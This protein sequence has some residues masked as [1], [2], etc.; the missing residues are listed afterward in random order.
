M[1]KTIIVFYSEGYCDQVAKALSEYYQKLADEV[2]VLL[3]NEAQYTAWGT[4]RF[5]DGLYRFSMR[6][7]PNINRFGGFISYQYN[8]KFKNKMSKNVKETES[9]ETE[10][11][12]EEKEESFKKLKTRFRKM[13]NILLRFNP[14]VVV[15]TTPVSLE[16]ALK[17]RERLKMPVQICVAITDYCTN[18]GMINH[19]VDK[20]LVQNAKI[21]QT[22]STF[23]INEDIVDVL[24]TPICQSIAEEYDRKAQLEAF[25]VTNKDLKNILIVS[26]RCGCARVI[27]AFKDI[28]PY[29][30]E[31]NIFVMANDSRNIHSFVKSYTKASKSTENIYLI[32]SIDDMAKLYS[33][34]DVIVTSP[35]AA[36]TYEAAVRGIP[37]VLL[38]PANQLEEG[39]F[40]YLSTNGYAFIGEKT[41]H[42]VPTVL[43]LV[44]GENPDGSKLSIKKQPTNVAK[45]YGDSI[46]AMI[47]EEMQKKKQEKAKSKKA[48]AAKE[49]VE[50]AVVEDK[51][52]DK[53]K[54]DT[55][56]KK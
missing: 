2:S 27:D 53:A 30:Q 12:V 55:K 16:K 50:D 31:M 1:K 24:G 20:F 4:R 7:F 40:Q 13:D 22:L 18:R 9:Q 32:D 25:G 26:G 37:C 46:L 35:T 45:A 43:S 49:A 42:L 51:K 6:Y 34:T 10:V 38:K 48:K 15:C 52:D 17:A 11:A 29:T 54:K 41:S 33:I 47:S 28:A 14:D 39:N 56:K 21:K 36:I 23:G 3:I 19:G 8:E 44:K 5:K